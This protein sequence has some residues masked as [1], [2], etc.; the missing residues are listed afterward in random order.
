MADLLEG[1]GRVMAGVGVRSERADSQYDRLEL[2]AMFV[3][4]ERGDWGHFQLNY[5]SK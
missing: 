1:P 4:I 5:G 3:E 2:W